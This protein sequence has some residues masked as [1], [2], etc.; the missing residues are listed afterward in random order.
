MNQLRQVK[1]YDLTTIG[2][3][4]RCARECAG[5]RQS[6]LG[7]RIGMPA[8]SISAMELGRMYMPA[9]KV[10]GICM[11][12]SIKRT[13]LLDGKGPGPAAPYGILRS[14]QSPRQARATSR[15]K[16]R[17]AALVEARARNAS[18]ASLTAMAVPMQS[19]P[20]TEPTQDIRASEEA[21][22]PAT[23]EQP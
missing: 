8:R 5:M 16:L 23:L 12:L 10:A 15:A 17:A 21:A 3:R 7:R 22:K 6:E 11:S 19:C 9:V 4:L 20:T 14:E 2:G 1:L 13:W 18:R